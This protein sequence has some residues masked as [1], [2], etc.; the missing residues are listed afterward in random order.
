VGYSLD[1]NLR[2]RQCPSTNCTI[3]SLYDLDAM[4][5][6]KCQIEGQDVDG[7]RIW[8]QTDRGC[9]TADTRIKTGMLRIPNVPTCAAAT[10]SPTAGLTETSP[11][12][13]PATTDV[14]T[15]TCEFHGP[16][17]CCVLVSNHI[18]IGILKRTN[19]VCPTSHPISHSLCQ[20]TEIVVIHVTFV[21]S[22]TRIL[23]LLTIE[24]D[25]APHVLLD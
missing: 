19:D 5:V 24:F 22:S 13:T 15:Q 11:A 6:I 10:A 7:N 2:C 20:R 3:M 23:W 21:M 12:P 17:L 4:I 14:A 8:A 18:R 1:N 16:S 25:L 9:F